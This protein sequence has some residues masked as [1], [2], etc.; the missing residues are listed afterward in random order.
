MKLILEQVRATR[1]DWQFSA[2]A[3]FLPGIHLVTGRVGSG[4]TTL[5]GVVAGTLAPGSGRVH[6]EGIGSTTLS[7]QY[8]EYHVT[9]ATLAKEA[10]SYGVSPDDALSRAALSG[11]GADDPFILSRGELKWFH[12]ACLSLRRWD[13]L[14]LDEPFSALDCRGKKRACEQIALLSPGIVLVCT[15]EQ[16]HLPRTDF[17]WEMQNGDLH[18]LGKVPEALPRWQTAPKAVRTLLSQGC[19][20]ANLTDRD[21]GEALCRIRD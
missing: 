21:L 13:L 7:L 9:G 16:Q 20:P 3:T 6:R 11:R 15:H 19:I 14:V 4:K 10:A 1:G 12:L 8:P 18:Y 17:L 2:D 5:A